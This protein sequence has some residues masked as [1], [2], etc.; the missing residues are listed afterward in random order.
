[1][2]GC[3]FMIVCA[4]GARLILFVQ[5]CRDWTDGVWEGALWPI[6][7]WIFMP[8]TTLAYAFATLHAPGKQIVG[9]WWWFVFIAVMIDLGFYGRT[10]YVQSKKSE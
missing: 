7:G 6:L 9:D 4:L 10:V 8:W 5:Y 3:L 1:M 2:L